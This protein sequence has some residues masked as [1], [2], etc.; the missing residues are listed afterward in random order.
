MKFDTIIIGGGLS[1]LIAGLSLVNEGKKVAIV[2]TGQSALHFWSGSFDLLSRRPDG[3]DVDNPLAEMENLDP[4]HPYRRIGLER[5]ALLA[6]SLKW[7]LA[8]VGVKV[9]GNEQ[10]NHYRISP[11]GKLRP[12]WL[13]LEDYPMLDNPAEMP[14]KTVTLV[15]LKGYLDFY[16]QFLS[17]SLE[18]AGVK[19]RSKII[20]LPALENLR[21]STTEMRAPN[22]ARV[23]NGDVLGDLIYELKKI[24]G[25]TDALLVPAIFGLNDVQPLEQL[26]YSLDVPVYC[27]PT[28][29]ASVPGI[30]TQLQMRARFQG[31]GGVYMLGDQVTGGTFEGDKLKSISTANLG[32]DALTA[33]NYILATGS[34]FGHGLKALPQAIE[35]TVFG[36]DVDFSEDRSTW[37]KSDIYAD[38]P[39]MKFGVKT[40]DKLHAVRGGKAVN[41][42]YAAGSILGGCNPLKDGCGAGV[43]I[44]SAMHVAGMIA[45]K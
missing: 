11:V 35:E 32:K 40:D 18:K 16:P 23:M 3:S 26:R 1:G 21:H 27:V 44:I 10:K 39:F 2:S 28:I 20:T 13:T 8:R 25:D 12:T 24:S 36:L 29:P 38:Q 43:A 7:H 17:L 34:F 4:S 15:G 19:C 33:D 22:I 45:G 9:N 5:V 14:W 31:R 37:F 30:R 6:S 42:L 41:N